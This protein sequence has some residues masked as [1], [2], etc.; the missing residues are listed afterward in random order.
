MKFGV[1]NGVDFYVVSSVKDGNFIHKLKVFLKRNVSIIY[2][3]SEN[4]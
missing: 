1:E 2:E 4:L 3:I